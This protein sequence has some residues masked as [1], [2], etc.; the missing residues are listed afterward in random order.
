MTTTLMSP[1]N[2]TLPGNETDI[3]PDIA[4]A[5]FTVGLFIIA[6]GGFGNIL[7]IVSVSRNKSLSKMSNV[8]VVSLAMCDLI[9]TL[10]VKPL[11]VYT[12]W[13]GSWQLGTHACIYALL[14][15]NFTILESILHVVVIA[16]YRYLIIVHPKKARYFLRMRCILVIFVCLFLLPMCI[17]LLPSLPRIMRGDVYF[18]TRIMFCSFVK[19]QEFHLARVLKKVIFLAIAAAFLFY[20]YVRIFYAVRKSRRSVTSQGQYSNS[21]IRNEFILLKTIIVVFVSFVVSYLPLSLLYGVDTKRQFPYVVYFFGVALLWMSSSINWVI[22]GCVNRQYCHAYKYVLC[23]QR[24][25]GKENNFSGSS[26]GSTRRPIP[27]PNRIHQ[28]HSIRTNSHDRKRK[29]NGSLSTQIGHAHKT[30]GLGEA[31]FTSLM[32]P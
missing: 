2:N 22:Y 3:P 26:G 5:G 31:G 15:S 10:L 30:P 13:V 20:F 12:Y 21:R 16:M 1:S 19:P 23:R 8:F 32:G 9:Q 7:I 29:M 18:N 4:V 6:L 14:A 25:N 28:A 27:L 17:F 24:T 11:Y